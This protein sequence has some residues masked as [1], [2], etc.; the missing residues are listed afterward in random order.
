MPIHDLRVYHLSLRKKGIKNVKLC[1][2]LKKTHFKIFYVI[3]DNLLCKHQKYY[4]HMY[5]SIVKVINKSL[6]HNK[7]QFNE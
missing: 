5:D 2:N 6:Q 1:Y 4:M 3:R 7:Q